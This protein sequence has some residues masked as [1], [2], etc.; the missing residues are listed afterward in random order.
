[1]SQGYEQRQVDD[2][3]RRDLLKAIGVAGAVTVGGASVDGI[4]EQMSGTTAASELA[5]VGKAINSDLAGELNATLIASQQSQIATATSELSAALEKGIPEAAPREEFAA[6]AEAGRPMY[7]HLKE[8]GFFESTTEHLPEFNPSYLDNAVTTFVGSEA[9]S[10]TLNGF[11]FV[12]G[13]PVDILATVIGN[14]EQLAESH[15]IS[16]E[17]ILRAEMEG[18]QYIPPMTMSAAGGALLWLGDIDQHLWN[19]QVLMTEDIVADAVW[20]G[21]ALGTGIHVMAE[22][23]KAIAEENAALSDAEL[24]GVLTTGFAVQAIS[25]G[26]LPQDVYWISEEMRDSRRTDLGLAVE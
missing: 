10:G 14:A 12:G 9:L 3:E 23:A 24:A 8:V 16:N 7:E 15:W 26:L 20:H 5:P 22:G 18:G 25:Q 6:V 2:E 21:Q 19:R 17:A 13:E 1:M 4:R 11:E